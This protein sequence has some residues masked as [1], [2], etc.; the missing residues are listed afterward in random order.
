MGFLHGKSIFFKKYIISFHSPQFLKFN[1]TA[2][3]WQQGSLALLMLSQLRGLFVQS[4]AE[5]RVGVIVA[6]LLAGLCLYRWLPERQRSKDKVLTEA[7]SLMMKEALEFIAG[8]EL[9][10][11]PEEESDL[12]GE[13]YHRES[14]S[15]GRAGNLPSS[16]DPG[17]VEMAELIS[18]GLSPFAA[19][20]WIRYRESGGAFRE[21]G[22]IMKIYGIDRG[23]AVK[24]TA[25][26]IFET[27]AVK[28]KPVIYEKHTIFKPDLNRCGFSYLTDSLMLSAENAAIILSYRKK[29]GG[30]I[31]PDQ[32]TE[33]VEL[34]DS[35]L[36]IIKEKTQIDTGG[37]RK[38]DLE[39]A[40]Y[41]ELVS[42]P[43]LSSKEVASILKFRTYSERTIDI[44]LL[45]DFGILTEETA[46]KLI[47][48]FK[49]AERNSLGEE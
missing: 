16:F 21:P 39:T 26:A 12:A 34:P 2:E 17:K 44:G 25:L 45:K 42:H 1:T 36:C 27:K 29:L 19:G 46:R 37:I 10:D 7:D 43:Y 11:V 20:N 3:I 8:L 22:D 49:T 48:Y 38:I 5:L 32:I 41:K 28:D 23:L 35:V 18:W 6:G 31:D 47:P 30:Y 13:R 24:L 15:T 33:A 14:E 40:T 9:R 4:V